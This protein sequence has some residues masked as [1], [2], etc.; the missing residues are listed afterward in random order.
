MLLQADIFFKV[1]QRHPIFPALGMSLET[2]MGRS[3]AVRQQNVPMD[4][5]ADSLW[6]H[7]WPNAN[8]H[9]IA[10]IPCAAFLL[11]QSEASLGAAALNAF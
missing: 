3:A 11:P 5:R 1:A 10:A 8:F 2:D 4:S 9:Y 6:P 7:E